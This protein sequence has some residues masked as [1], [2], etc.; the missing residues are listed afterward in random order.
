MLRSRS[1][2]P[3]TLT[4]G[5]LT[6]WVPPPLPGQVASPTAASPAAPTP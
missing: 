1:S 4:L 5:W 2:L 6:L 3:L